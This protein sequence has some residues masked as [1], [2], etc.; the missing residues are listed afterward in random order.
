MFCFSI[1]MLTIVPT[2]IMPMFNTYSP[3]E[4][5]ELKSSIENLAKRVSFPLTNLFSV[6]G[7]KR[8]AHSNAYFYGFF[9]NK[10]IV[11]YDTLIKQ[12]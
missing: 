11:L 9:K 3:L 1:L 5:G 4:D 8:S 6:D 12:V 10:R 7:S 2:V